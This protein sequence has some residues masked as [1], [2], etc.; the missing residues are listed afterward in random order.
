MKARPIVSFLV[1]GTPVPQGSKAA[2][3][4][5]VA[6]KPRAVLY[7]DNDKVLKPWRKKVTEVAKLAAAAITEPLVDMPIVVVIEFR[8]VR[9]KSVKREFPTVKPDTDKLERS[10]LDALTDAHVWDDDSRVVVLKGSKVY[11][12]SAGA[13]VQVGVIEGEEEQ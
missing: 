6:G 12:E 2:R 9:P 7:N 13:F 8:F 3:V 5:F 1:E 10:I 4:V 11:A